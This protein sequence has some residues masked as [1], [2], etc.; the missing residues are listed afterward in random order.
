MDYLK[1]VDE[2]NKGEIKDVSPYIKKDINMDLEMMAIENGVEILNDLD[3]I[4]DGSI[5]VT[6]YF[7]KRSVIYFQMLKDYT[8]LEFLGDN[9][10]SVENYNI[11]IEE[12]F[13]KNVFIK[14][15]YEGVNEVYHSQQLIA[16]KELTNALKNVPSVEDVEKMAKD[17]DN[18]L[19]DKNS[20]K[21]KLLNDV[22]VFNDPSMKMLKDT[23][24]NTVQD[25]SNA[26]HDLA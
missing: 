18:V 12:E 20:E 21:L 4:N 8:T 26:S 25:T 3:R 10:D 19:G 15:Y 7:M 6:E 16:I 24:Y 17:F 9:D 22:M 14:R 23:I 11:A 5:P 13:K 1:F 2:F